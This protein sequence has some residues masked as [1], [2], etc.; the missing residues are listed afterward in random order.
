MTKTEQNSKNFSRRKFIGDAVALGT[1]G[2]LGMNAVISSCSRQEKYVAP[3]FPD[4]APDGPVIRAGLVGCG[5]RGTG[6]ALNFLNA[7]PNLELVALGDLFQ[8]RMDRCREILK[9]RKDV[10]ISDD[11]CFLGFDAY[12]KVID[13]DIDLVL[14]CQPPYF[15]AVSFDYAIKAGKHAFIEKPVGVDPTGVRSVRA[16]GKIAE[17]AGLFVLAGTHYRHLRDRVKAYEMVKNGAI[18][19]IISVNCYYNMAKLWHKDREKGWSDMEAMI[20][21]WVNWRWLSGDHIVEQHIHELDTV[22]WFTGKLPVKCV[23]FGGRHR[24]LTG[25]QY[26]FFS[27][28]FVYDDGKHMHSMCRQISGCANNVSTLFFGTK[29]YTDGMSTIWDYNGNVLWE[30]EYPKNDEGKPTNIP[31]VPPHDQEMINLIT[32]LRTNKYV[33]DTENVSNANIMAI[34]GRESAYTGKEMSFDEI[35]NSDMKL[36]PEELA[37]GPVNIPVKIPVPGIT[38]V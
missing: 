22:N 23:A 10:E 26:D 8:D 18:G 12:K 21:D 2:T 35:M 9:K 17:S 14:L 24:R 11:K 31:S 1:I 15:R 38:P 37:M 4:K 19:D 16:S 5:G 27:V 20:R 13:S 34:M 33:N 25:D 30:Y 7:G 3:V 6:A 29:G 36:G 28:D 32:A